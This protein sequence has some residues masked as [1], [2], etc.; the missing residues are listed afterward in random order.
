MTV[1]GE[2][3][4]LATIL[5][6]TLAPT[7]EGTSSSLAWLGDNSVHDPLQADEWAAAEVGTPCVYGAGLGAG[8]LLEQRAP[9]SIEYVSDGEASE[10]G[11]STDE[12]PRL[13]IVAP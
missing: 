10:G 7:D 6:D 4:R 1:P 9:D 11:G 3:H 13:A 2:R 8:A 12:A 5:P